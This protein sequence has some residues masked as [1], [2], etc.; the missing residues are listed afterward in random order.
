MPPLL[1]T[2]DLKKHYRMGTSTVRAL[3]GVSLSI[4]QG[5]FVALSN[6]PHLLLADEPTGNLDSRASR[7]ESCAVG[8]DSGA[9]T[10]LKR[11]GGA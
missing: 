9:S 2:R 5:E 1:E 6:K 11:G 8:S 3:D 7:R 4:H 10:R